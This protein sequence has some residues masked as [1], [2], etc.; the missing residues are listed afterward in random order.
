MN[1]F[2]GRAGIAIGFASLTLGCGDGAA[3]D[4]STGST[5]AGAG[6]GPPVVTV[7]TPDAPPLPG[8]SACTV[9]IT[10]NVAFEGHTHEDV[11]TPI[12]YVSNPPSSGN[13]WPIW[14]KFTTYTQ[15][16]R[17]EMLVHDMEHGAIVMSYGCSDCAEV[18]AAFEKAASDFGIDPLCATT[19]GG[20]MR[21]R[22]VITPDPKIPTPIAMSSWRSTYTATCIDPESILAFVKEHYGHGSEQLC[23][24]GKDP[25]DPL[26]P[27]D[28][29]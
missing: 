3:D 19:E 17:R 2:F 9:T 25:F 24:D 29:P 6:G 12:T 14:A 5:G 4:T 20:A 26:S 10:D 7:L 22:I 8:Q 1:I 23:N 16:V 13:H 27:I 21:S 28:C 18:P 11:C 15:P